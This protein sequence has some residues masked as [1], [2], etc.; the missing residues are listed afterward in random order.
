MSDVSELY[1]SLWG[2]IVGRNVGGLRNVKDLGV[3]I[4]KRKS[5]GAI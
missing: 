5:G 4:I 1:D 2:D 3:G